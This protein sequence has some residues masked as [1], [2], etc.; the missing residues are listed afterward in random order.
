ILDA[1]RENA[2]LA[3]EIRGK[4]EIRL[5]GQI[6]LVEVH[7]V[8]AQTGGDGVRH[9]VLRGQAQVREDPPERAAVARPDLERALETGGVHDSGPREN[10]LDDGLFHRL[11][12]PRAPAGAAPPRYAS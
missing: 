2:A 8:E 5:G 1:E 3:A 7:V 12:S 6:G 10:F 4:A 9:G 11:A